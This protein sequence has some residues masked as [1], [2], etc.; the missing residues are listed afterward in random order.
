MSFDSDDFYMEGHDPDHEKFC[1]NTGFITN[2]EDDELSDYLIAIEI[3]VTRYPEPSMHVGYGT[4][5]EYALYHTKG[6]EELGAF[7]EIFYWLRGK[8]KPPQF[9]LDSY[10]SGLK[11]R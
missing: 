3:F 5:T 10:F 4:H 2:F 1:V 8:R 6:E 11:N 7:W 9:D